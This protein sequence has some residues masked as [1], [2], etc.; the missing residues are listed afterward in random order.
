MLHS[1]GSANSN[2]RLQHHAKIV[3][4]LSGGLPE[5]RNALGLASLS[6]LTRLAAMGGHEP[7]L[8]QRMLEERAR[9]MAAS[10]ASDRKQR[11]DM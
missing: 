10:Q 2:E 8:D 4:L 5:N 1:D 6:E 7:S 9:I 3:R 11:I